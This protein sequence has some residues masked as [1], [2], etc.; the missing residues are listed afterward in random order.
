MELFVCDSCGAV[1]GVDIAYPQGVMV[2]GKPREHWECTECQTG[3][4]HE[5][6]DKEQYKPGFDVVVNRPNGLGLEE[7]Q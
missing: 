2:E 3:S 1:D 4:W 7:Q 6:F 5:L